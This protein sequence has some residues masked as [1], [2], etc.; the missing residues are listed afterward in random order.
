MMKALSIRQPWAWLIVHGWKNIENRSWAT[1]YRGN[2]LIHAAKTMT[3]A[4]YEACRIFV[5]S[6]H[7]DLAMPS[8]SDLPRGGIVGEVTLSDCVRQHSSPWFT[9]PIG[10]VLNEAC[11]CSLIPWRARLGIFEVP[12]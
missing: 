10:W 12:E 8:P 1:C 5:D 2:L 4:D 9:G 6:I 11:C 7:D 3:L